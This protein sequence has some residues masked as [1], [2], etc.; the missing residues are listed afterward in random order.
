MRLTMRWFGPS[1]KIKLEYIKQIPG[2]KGIV[3]AIYDVA[4][5]EV[6]PKEK[7]LALK[8]DIERHGLTLDVIE[9]VPVHEDIKLG[10]PTRDRYIENY[11]QTLRHLA[12]CGIDTVCYNF[13]PVFDWT[14]SQL[15]F[16][17]EDGSE[18][19]IYEEDVISRTNP[20][21]GEL[22]LP[23][24]DTSYQNESLKG[25]LQAY[26]KIGEED[27]WDHLTYFVQAIMPVADEVGIKMAIHPDDPPWSIFGLPRIITNKANLERLL[28]LH[29]SPNHGITMCSGSLGANEAN[30]LPEMIRHF[31]GQG[32][33]HFAHARNIKRTGPRSFQ[34]SAHLSEAGSV[35]M[36]AMLKAYHDIGFIGP[37]RPDHGRMIWG[38]Q[39]RPGYGLYDRAL[40]ATYLNGIWEAVSS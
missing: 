5:G 6:W 13:M 22:E 15:D 9:S 2:M 32:R 35:N 20:L 1:D 29:D 10:K 14:R 24:W 19:L 17:L 38:E 33:I 12:E 18:A 3:S 31:G 34:E 7:I 25:V 27:L 16:K 30:D 23:G 8:N 21:S 37:L 26:K 4:V 36:V 39:G 40:G 28:S 11:K